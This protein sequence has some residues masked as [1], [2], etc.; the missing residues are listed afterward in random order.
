[1]PRTPA[2]PSQTEMAVLGALSVQPM[3]AYAMR[4]AI[5]D[6]L[7]HFWSESFGQIYPTLKRLAGEAL[8]EPVGS[9]SA[10]RKPR[11]EAVTRLRSR[12]TRALKKRSVR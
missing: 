9:T 11:Q 4:E 12:S 5:R 3:T 2:R 10:G 1:M 8:I 7:G 6:V